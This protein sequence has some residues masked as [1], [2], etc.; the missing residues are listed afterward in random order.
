[1]SRVVHFEIPVE[2]IEASIVFY[3]KVFGWTFQM[4]PGEAKNQAAAH[5]CRTTGEAVCF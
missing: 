2:N 3:Q 4:L 5:Y 1:M